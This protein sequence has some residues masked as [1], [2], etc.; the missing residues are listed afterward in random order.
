MSDQKKQSDS[1]KAGLR[2]YI[3]YHIMS[4]ALI[5]KGYNQAIDLI[6]T[7]LKSNGIALFKKDNDIYEMFASQGMSGE[8]ITQAAN[9]LN[10]ELDRLKGK[11]YITVDINEEDGSNLIF[12]PVKTRNTKY[13]LVARNIKNKEEN[14]LYVFTEI[15]SHALSVVLET[16]EA[17]DIVEKNSLEDGLTKL[18]NRTSYNQ[19][20]SELKDNNK[21]YVFALLDLFRLKFVNDNLSHAAGDKYIK[22][23]AEILKSYFPKYKMVKNDEGVYKK[24]ETGTIVYRIGGD[25]FAIISSTM[26]SDELEQKIKLA[27]VDVEELDLHEETKPQLGLNYGIATRDLNE[28]IEDLYIEADKRLSDNKREMYV[29]LGLDRRR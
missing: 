27:S 26:T 5:D 19:K 16:Q 10:D 7:Y 3:G 25:E 4:N 28:R 23:V 13:L 8:G 22:G 6:R 29:K 12:I 21:P 20:A 17:Y 2:Y 18:D 15:I 11:H 14:D 9:I 24:Q 1:L